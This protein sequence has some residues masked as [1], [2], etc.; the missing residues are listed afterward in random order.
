MPTRLLTTGGQLVELRAHLS[1]PS[2]HAQ[3]VRFSTPDA[4][5]VIRT[6]DKPTSRGFVWTLPLTCE[7]FAGKEKVGY[8]SYY[9]FLAADAPAFISHPRRRL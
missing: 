1:Q 7:D 2:C 5:I 8:L 3:R 4:A 9:S 6:A